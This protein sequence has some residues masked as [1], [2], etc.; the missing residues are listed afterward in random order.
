M[1]IIGWQCPECK[2]TYFN[3]CLGDITC[4][5][6]GLVISEKGIDIEEGI[7]Q[8][9]GPYYDVG[10]TSYH[11]NKGSYIDRKPYDCHGEK[12]S[13]KMLPTFVRLKKMQNLKSSE[14]MRIQRAMSALGEMRRRLSRE[15]TLTKN[16]NDKW[17]A[18]FKE[19]LKKFSTRGRSFEILTAATF[20]WAYREDGNMNPIKK[21][22]E[23]TE[24]TTGEIFHYYQVLNR[25]FLKMKGT[26]SKGKEYENEMVKISAQL[27]LPAE[28][29]NLALKNFPLIMKKI[30]LIGKSVKALMGA[31]F[32]MLC[33]S[34]GE[35]K[36]QEEI[37]IASGVTAVTLRSRMKELEKYCSFLFAKSAA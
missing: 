13:P 14:E 12:I 10:H 37:A 30:P 29:E 32:Y 3:N 35:K 24:I 9:E 36:S 31:I 17:M 27:N 6:C 1:E 33:K 8:K 26:E 34:A 25:L 16:F 23:I 2:S 21:V 11:S 18:R 7:K 5:Q 4:R 15:F 22:A 20:C 28:I 19:F